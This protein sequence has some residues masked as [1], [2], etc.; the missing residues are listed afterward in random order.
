MLDP[1]EIVYD[2]AQDTWRFRSTPYATVEFENQEAYDTFAEILSIAS[3]L[4]A[5]DYCHNYQL[6][7]P[8]VV[9]YINKMTAIQRRAKK[10]GRIPQLPV[11][12]DEDA[13]T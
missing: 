13:E 10:L 3:D 7:D 9:D 1:L 8:W 12:E 5:L 4:S 6:S 2:E 11:E